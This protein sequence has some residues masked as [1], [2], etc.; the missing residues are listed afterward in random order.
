M[1]RTGLLP[2]APIPIDMGLYDRN[3]T[4]NAAALLKSILNFVDGEPRI[5]SMTAK[6]GQGQC[7][8]LIVLGGSVSVYYLPGPL[9]SASINEKQK[10]WP[11]QLEN[12]LNDLF[13]C[14]GGAGRHL[15]NNVAQGGK[16]THFW[17]KQIQTV[18]SQLKGLL[19]EADGVLLDVDINDIY[20]NPLSNAKAKEESEVLLFLLAA[21]PNK[22]AV[23]YIGTSSWPKCKFEGDMGKLG[24]CKDWGQKDEWNNNRVSLREV[25]LGSH[26]EL[27]RHYSIP[28]ISQLEGLG[29]FTT[30]E[31]LRFWTS[32]RIDGV[33]LNLLGHMIL[34]TMVGN[35]FNMLYSS[36]QHP[37]LAGEVTTFVQT[38]KP[39]L[40][41]RKSEL[42]M[43]IN[44]KVP[45]YHVDPLDLYQRQW[46]GF[47]MTSNGFVVQED[48]KGKPGLIG[49]HI[50][51]HVTFGIPPSVI[52]GNNYGVLQIPIFHSYNNVGSVNVTVSTTFATPDQNCEP[53]GSPSTKLLT[54]TFV[55][56]LHHI[57]AS[58]SE[59]TEVKYNRSALLEG[60]R[61]HCLN[62]KFQVVA[63]YPTREINK[64]KLFGFHVY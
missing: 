53:V 46:G 31:Q 26:L 4:L 7:L 44:S 13:P 43:Y 14:Q 16:G 5:A 50:G 32:C 33:H 2:A 40:F 41:V 39:L 22:P 57:R 19:K 38:D 64:I 3:V 35:Y 52:R 30:S 12:M 27:A 10:T 20:G 37:I 11:Q 49:H 59:S 36:Y 60:G 48:M 45:P 56:C 17:I 42:D 18:N 61:E 24:R 15:V 54:Y 25:T 51:D 8:K 21:L 9:R 34:G 62:V 6:M 63:S 1:P 23:I 28:Y 55:D 58:I 47:K 29:P